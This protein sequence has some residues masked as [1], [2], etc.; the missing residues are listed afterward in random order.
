MAYSE[1]E[2][3]ESITKLIQGAQDQKKET[4]ASDDS[5]ARKQIQEGTFSRRSIL[6][7]KDNY[8]AW[9]IRVKNPENFHNVKM[10]LK[11]NTFTLP[12]G[13]V[14]AILFFMY[15]IPDRPYYVH[16]AFNIQDPEVRRYLDRSFSRLTW[17]VEI[18]DD[19]HHAPLEDHSPVK[20]CI[21]LLSLSEAKF[22]EA[23]RQALS[24]NDNLKEPLDG[25]LAL[26]NYLALFEAALLKHEKPLQA[27]QDIHQQL[28]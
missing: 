22:A 4:W 6:Y 25:E 15:D 19:E 12:Q 9:T 1:D 2:P 11:I 27:W 18:L 28:S 3:P 20:S 23:Y 26:V 7:Y 14:L 16:R 5:S 17:Y 21:H 8:P 24:Y 10:E 13:S